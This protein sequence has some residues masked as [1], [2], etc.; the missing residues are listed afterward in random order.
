MKNQK[1]NNVLSNETEHGNN[2]IKILNIVIIL[3]V[4][5]L[6]SIIGLY[7][8]AR[9]TTA[10][11]GA[12]EAQIAKWHF[13]V[14]AGSSDTLNIDLATTRFANDTEHADGSTVA[15]GTSG[16][17]E[18]NIDGSGTETF[19]EYCITL[20]LTNVPQNLIFYSDANMQNAYRK[21]N[22]QI[23]IRGFFDLNSNK[24]VT[25]MLYWRWPFETGNSAEEIRINDAIDSQFMDGRDITM[26]ILATGTQVLG[27]TKVIYFNANGGTGTMNSQLLPYGET[28]NLNANQFTKYNARFEGWT[29]NADGSGT[30]YTDEQEISNLN[31]SLNLYAK[32]HDFNA[33]FQNGGYVN[34]KMNSLAGRPK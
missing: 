31:G 8:Y 24:T 4:C 15:P 20:D 21:E 13:N 19:L 29:T 17:L 5:I 33:T 30:V 6:L 16:A 32:W 23:N 11:Q 1:K 34:S 2:K 7:A 18:L 9:Y 26:S 22:N 10:R 25:Q 3:L 12:S 28:R 27:E 14:T